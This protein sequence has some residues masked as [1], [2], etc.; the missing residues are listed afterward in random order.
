MSLERITTQRVLEELKAGNSVFILQEADMTS[1]TIAD[2]LTKEFAIEVPEEDKQSKAPKTQG[3]KTSAKKKLDWGKIQALH[4]AGW[5]HVKI[6]DEMGCT[7]GTVDTGL[8][9][10]R[11]GEN[12]G[13]E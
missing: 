7:V 2:W 4:N 5:S 6:A 1:V 13:K 9:R 3:G 12:N 10:L 11:K 8:S